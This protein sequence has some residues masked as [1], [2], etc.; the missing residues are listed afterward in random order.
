MCVFIG[1]KMPDEAIGKNTSNPLQ[2][3]FRQPKLHI[4]LPSQGKYYPDGGLEMSDN[5]EVA[6]FP[7]TAKDELLLKTP[8]SLMNGTAT[9]DVIASCVP[10]IK[11]PWYM[12][13][14]DVDAVLMAIRIATYGEKMTLTVK[15][16]EIGDEKDYEIDLTTVMENI[17]SA[18]YENVILIDNMKITLR[19][20]TYTEFTTDAIKSFEEQRVYSL[21]N[22][23]TVPSEQK[24]ERFRQAFLRLTDLTVNTVAKSINQIEVDGQIVSEPKHILEFMQNV[25]KEFYTKI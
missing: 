5:G 21:I 24:M 17:M 7:L 8:D 25:S 18:R 11:Q 12:P 1:D 19:P 6:V 16:P 3:Y 23:D 9:A 2:K 15:V 4:R 13:S 14:L 10:A 20:L 22:D